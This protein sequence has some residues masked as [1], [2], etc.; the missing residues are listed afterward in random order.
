M[1]REAVVRQAPLPRTGAGPL[2]STRCPPKAVICNNGGE[3]LPVTLGDGDRAVELA[4]L[5]R[6]EHGEEAFL[7][8]R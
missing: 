1:K 8:R 2:F 7:W 3:A 6:A 4:A 5:T